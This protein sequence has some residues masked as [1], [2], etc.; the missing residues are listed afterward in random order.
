VI[1]VSAIRKE[2][3]VAVKFSARTEVMR[4]K[5][6]VALKDISPTIK[7]DAVAIPRVSGHAPMAIASLT[8]NTAMVSLNAQIE[9]MRIRNSV[10]SE[11]ILTIIAKFV[12]AILKPNGP[13][14]T[15]VA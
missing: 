1:T 2:I 4:V 11:S 5:R 10:V 8:Q 12:V 15:V 7:K 6:N 9:V 13:V 14:T 3:S